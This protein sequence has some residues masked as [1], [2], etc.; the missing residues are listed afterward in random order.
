MGSPINTPRL[1]LYIA[2]DLPN[3][4]RARA[5]L[6][7]WLQRAA[8]ASDD[9]EVVDVLTHPERAAEE[10][11]FMTPALVF[12]GGSGRQV[13]V[14]DLSDGEYLGDLQANTSDS[15]DGV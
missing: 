7:A 6:E 3:S 12:S 13:F 11:I 14:G 2:G 10:D 9:V 15:H 4:R 1:T 8:I 5:H